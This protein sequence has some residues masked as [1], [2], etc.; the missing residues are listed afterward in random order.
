MHADFIYENQIEHKVKKI[1]FK[2]W[3]K[4]HHS[5]TKENEER[6]PNW[7]KKKTVYYME[8]L[9]EKIV[10]ITFNILIRLQKKKIPS[11]IKHLCK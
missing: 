1:C 6:N 8:F 3:E 11:L 9:Y 4:K 10:T 2:F 5:R 7:K